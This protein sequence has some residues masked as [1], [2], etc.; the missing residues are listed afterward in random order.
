MNKYLKISIVALVCLVCG[1]PLFSAVKFTPVPNTP[2]FRE[3]IAD[4]YAPASKF[5]IVSA[6]TEDSIP[7]TIYHAEDNQ[8]VEIPFKS[9][10]QANYFNMKAGANIGFLRFEAGFFQIEIYLN[11]GLNAIFELEG[12][13][14]LLGF[15][16]FYSA[17]LSIR[18]WDVVAL[19]AGI[20]HFS[21]HWG[22]EILAKMAEI[23][24]SANL[25]T[26]SLLE[27]TRDNSWLI[28]L[29]IEP[30]KTLRFYTA[31]EIPMQAAWIRP[32]AHV[33]SFAVKP[34]EAD[35]P[36]YEHIANQEGVT[37][38]EY[39]DSYLAMRI[40]A[41]TEVKFP[42]L[43]VGSF[44]VAGDIQ[45]HQDGQTNHQVNSYDSDNPWEITLS[46][47]GGFEF[48]QSYFDR[49]LRIEAF[50]HYGRFPLLNFFYQ[51]GHYI[52]VGFSVNG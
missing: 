24:P 20:H 3:F 29:S 40:Q 28:S 1:S 33:P 32:A 14:D 15:D 23:N 30:I 26:M 45:F 39:S 22:D 50:Y 52:T 34:K 47:G 49:R 2:L 21:G 36:L 31:F 4:P 7:N 10:G 48:N 12:A 41:G 5:H 13:T 6:L 43:S 35:K 46:V 27:Y 42:L 51:R 19:Q 25:G 16:G 17:G 44:F 37:P 38:V 8:Y 11:G 18:L 9:E